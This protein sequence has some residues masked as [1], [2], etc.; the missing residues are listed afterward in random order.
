MIWNLIVV[1]KQI[2]SA[3][4]RWFTFSLL[5][6]GYLTIASSYT[7]ITLDLLEIKKLKGKKVDPP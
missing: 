5:L 1:N 2:T 7:D 4:N 6:I 3:Y